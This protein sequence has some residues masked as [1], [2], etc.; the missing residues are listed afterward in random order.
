[1]EYVVSYP[2]N[3]KDAKAVVGKYTVVVTCPHCGGV[4]HHSKVDLL[5]LWVASLC[6][7][8][9]YVLKLERSV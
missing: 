8:G 1:M 5:K 9:S 3:T 6:G 7:K 2:P 4:H